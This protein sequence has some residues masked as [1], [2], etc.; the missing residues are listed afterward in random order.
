MYF[1]CDRTVSDKNAFLN[2]YFAMAQQQGIGL[3]VCDFS[4]TFKQP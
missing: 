2:S 1:H 3:K 4:K